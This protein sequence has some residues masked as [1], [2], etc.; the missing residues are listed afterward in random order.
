MLRRA[1]KH[2]KIIRFPGKMARRGPSRREQSGAAG[3]IYVTRVFMAIAVPF[4]LALASAGLISAASSQQNQSTS[5]TSSPAGDP[6]RAA[7]ASAEQPLL[8]RYCMG[9]HNARTKSGNF[10]LEGLDVAALADHAEEW[11][12]VV[13]KLRGGLMP[14]AGRPRPDEATYD[15]LRTSIESR[16][17]RAAAAR[18]DPGRT[19]IAHRLNRLEYANAVRDLLAVEISAPDLLPADDS[20]YGFDNIAGVLKM[21]GSLTE[22]YLG[23]ARVISRLAI[24]SPPP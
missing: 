6:S 9:C 12:K 8:N 14:P 10:V 17:D 5:T 15:K 22:R 4:V 16:L 23:A 13:R 19:E 18:P 7:D 2:R 3:A 24:G 20:S 1:D 11:E 21:S